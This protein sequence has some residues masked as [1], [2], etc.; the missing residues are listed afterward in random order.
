MCVCV[1]QCVCKH[2]FVLCV[3]VSISFCVFVSG[4]GLAVFENVDSAK[5]GTVCTG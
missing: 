3:R 5:D 1:W 4:A 2:V